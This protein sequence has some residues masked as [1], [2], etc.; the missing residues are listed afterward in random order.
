MPSHLCEILWISYPRDSDNRGKGVTVKGLTTLILFFAF[1]AQSLA[2]GQTK[3][4]DYETTQKS[5]FWNK[6]Y[7]YGG[8]TLYCGSPFYSKA[9]GLQRETPQ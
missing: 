4:P 5:Y 1:S 3:I 9:T 2:A 7:K 8:W 6:L